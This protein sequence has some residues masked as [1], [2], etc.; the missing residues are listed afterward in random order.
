MMMEISC[1]EFSK[2]TLNDVSD[3]LLDDLDDHNRS[4]SAA[5]LMGKGSDGRR[6]RL[7]VQLELVDDD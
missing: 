5:L 4:R 2:L 7:T 1:A 3:L 6:Y